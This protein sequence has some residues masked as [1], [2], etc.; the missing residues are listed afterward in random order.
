MYLLWTFVTKAP[1]APDEIKNII[2]VTVIKEE[3]NY[4]ID[5]VW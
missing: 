3:G 5:E 4:K 1:S 2:H